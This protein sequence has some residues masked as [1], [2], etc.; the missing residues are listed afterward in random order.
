MRVAIFGAG[1]MARECAKFLTQSDQLVLVANVVDSSREP[2]SPDFEQFLRLGN[3]N[4]IVSQFN[5]LPVID[6]LRSLEIDL[7]FSINN[8]QIIESELRESIGGGI[9]NFHNGPLPRYAGLNACSWAIYNG[10]TDHGVTWHW[11]DA[12][13]D[14]GELVAQR[15]FEIPPDSTSRQLIMRSISAG[16]DLFG[17]VVSHCEQG[18]LARVPQATSRRLFYSSREVPG[19]AEAD[20]S[21]TIGQMD[22]LVRALNFIPLRSPFP[23]L[24]ASVMGRAFFID[25]VRAGRVQQSGAP[26]TLT[27]AD[28]VLE[29]QVSD[30]TLELTKVRDQ[31]GRRILVSSLIVDYAMKPGMYLD[32]ETDA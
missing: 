14:S 19:D 29:V 6:F 28:D 5:E 8:H 9:I 31:D 26:G 24:R 18:T 11:V 27:R 30:G 13:I 17:E 21:Q 25:E 10:E 3:F 1:R 23:P 15:M 16:I 2:L 32:R 12:G 20:F 7:A 22:R 4:Y